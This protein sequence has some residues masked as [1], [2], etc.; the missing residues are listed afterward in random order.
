M[1]WMS[2]RDEK[3]PCS[4]IAGLLSFIQAARSWVNFNLT[5]DCSYLKLLTYHTYPSVSG[6]QQC[7]NPPHHICMNCKIFLCDLTPKN[8]LKERRNNKIMTPPCKK[9]EV[10]LRQVKTSDQLLKCL[11]PEWSLDPSCGAETVFHDLPGSLT[12]S[13]TF[14][15]SR[16]FFLSCLTYWLVIIILSSIVFYK[17]LDTSDMNEN[18]VLV[19]YF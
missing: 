2:W 19:Q 13:L 12:S 6:E 10:M 15:R 3:T 7:L 14:L 9:P 8:G 4:V 17:F 16:F 5:S 11:L 18:I 1:R